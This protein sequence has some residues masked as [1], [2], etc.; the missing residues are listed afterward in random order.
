MPI[1]IDIVQMRGM[2]IFEKRIVFVDFHLIFPKLF[3]NKLHCG[4]LPV[5]PPNC[6]CF[7]NYRWEHSF[8]IVYDLIGLSFSIK[9]LISCPLCYLSSIIIF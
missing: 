6:I 2:G 8:I 7:Q 5:P 4:D 1:D 9:K 3:M